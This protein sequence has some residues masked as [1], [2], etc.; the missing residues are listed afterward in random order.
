[1]ITCASCILLLELVSKISIAL[2]CFSINCIIL[3]IIYIYIYIYIYI[4]LH[5]LIC[6]IFHMIY[7]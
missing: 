1:M 3:N 6:L 4:A 2:I 5:V 7:M